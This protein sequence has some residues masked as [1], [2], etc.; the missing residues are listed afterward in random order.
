MRLSSEC[1]S[2]K[3]DFCVQLSYTV[4]ECITVANGAVTFDLQWNLC[5]V[6]TIWDKGH[7]L[8]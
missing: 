5:A 6:V 2:V 8:L 3:S 1:L 7:W 4:L